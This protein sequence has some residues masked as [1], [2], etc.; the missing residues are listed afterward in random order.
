MASDSPN[1]EQVS[2][3]NEISG[4][5]WVALSDTIDAQIAPLGREAMDRAEVRAGERVLDIG[6]GCGQTTLELAARVGARGRVLG[7]DVSAPMLRVGRERTEAAGLARVEFIEADAQIQA[8]ERG[9]A[10]LVFSRFGIMFFSDPGA[11]F[12]NL[13]ASLRPGGRITFVCWQEIAKN[14]WMLVPATAVGDLVTLPPAPTLG[15]SGPF[16]FADAE[17]V[18]GLLE[19]AG[20]AG[21]GYASLTPKLRIGVGMTLDGIVDFM[22]QMGPAGAALREAGEDVIHE[23]RLAAKEALAPYETGDGLSMESAAWVFSGRRPE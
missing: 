3:W 23:A 20:F 12:A 2:Y 14:P 13:L 17:R 9:A 4:P 5:K 18:K 16:A 21:V 8:F 11:A 22:L 19:G 1:A 7:I 10:D 15:S 6:C